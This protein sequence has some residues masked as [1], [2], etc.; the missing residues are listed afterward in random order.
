MRR[1]PDYKYVTPT[2]S[3][4]SEKQSTSS[5]QQS[6]TG[7]RVIT[8]RRARTSLKTRAVCSP[9]IDLVDSRFLRSYSKYLTTRRRQRRARKGE[10]AEIRPGELMASRIYDEKFSTAMQFLF[11]TLL[12]MAREDDDLVHPTQ[13]Q[14]ERRTT[15]IDFEFPRGL[16]SSA[17]TFQA[18][19][20]RY[21]S[22]QLRQIRST[23]RRDHRSG[24][25]RRLPDHPG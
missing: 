3:R 2:P 5:H 9:E 10:S 24:L 18:A 12:F 20:R 21:F 14:E 6:H 23:V 13:E 4:A 22:N 15:T 8:L 19:V 17:T 16:K 25:H 1:F 11:G 7:R